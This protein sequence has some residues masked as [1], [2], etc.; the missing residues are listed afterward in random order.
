MPSTQDNP[1]P[2]ASHDVHPA[3]TPAREDTG[4]APTTTSL[5]GSAKGTKAPLAA[6]Q[7]PEVANNLRDKDEEGFEV[8]MQTGIHRPPR[9]TRV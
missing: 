8:R 7:G 9:D 4:A 5:N 2:D 3:C 1:T 6:E